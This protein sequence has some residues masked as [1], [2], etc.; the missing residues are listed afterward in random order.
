MELKKILNNITI[1]STKEFREGLDISGIAY[2]S[3]K[4]VGN[5]LFVAIEGYVTDGHLY[6]VQ[7]IEKGAVAVVHEKELDNYHQNVSYIKVKDSRYALVLLGSSFY[8]D[9]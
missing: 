9:P 8:H 7:A 2:D 6:I 1:V 4:V 5:G 3:R